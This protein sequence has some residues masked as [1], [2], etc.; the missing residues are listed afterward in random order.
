MYEKNRRF[1]EPNG[2]IVTYD[3]TGIEIDRVKGYDRDFYGSYRNGYE[4]VRELTPAPWGEKEKETNYEYL[5]IA[6]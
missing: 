5:L 4:D 2:D 6:S 3:P 1:R